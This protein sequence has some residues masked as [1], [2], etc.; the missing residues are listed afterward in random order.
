MKRNG[1]FEAPPDLPTSWDLKAA[2][3]A[4]LTQPLLV[5]LVFALIAYV[6]V[7]FPLAVATRNTLH[8]E[9]LA[10]G[11]SLLRLLAASSSAQLAARR[12]EELSVAMVVGD[13]GV[14]DALILD[15]KDRI[16]APPERAGALLDILEGIDQPVG[17]IGGF[18]VGENEAGDLNMAMPIS[19]GGS[20][21][22]VA[23]LTFSLP[24]QA[25]GG[26]LLIL[27]LVGLLLI[28]IGAA[29]AILLAKKR[30]RALSAVASEPTI[31]ELP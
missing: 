7:A 21:V 12:I 22:G 31:A 29:S 28:L 18:V 24:H 1:T 17:E 16:L 14:Q 6:L 4:A 10:R 9:S 25:R 23:V 19:F 30:L 15:L 11:R 2:R 8:E 20:R 13:P 26:T 5:S 27:L 3:E